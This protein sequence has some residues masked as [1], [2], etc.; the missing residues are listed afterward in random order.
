LT[1]SV[2][3][4]Q[5]WSPDNALALNAD[6]YPTWSSESMFLLQW[7]MLTSPLVTVNLP[8]NSQIEYKYIRKFNGAITWESDPNNVINVPASGTFTENDTWR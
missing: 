1:G 3:E 7:K 5:N 4:L 8:A 2:N 6:N